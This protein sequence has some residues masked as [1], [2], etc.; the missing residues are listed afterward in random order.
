MGTDLEPPDWFK[1]ISK[2]VGTSTVLALFIMVCLLVLGVVG[3]M[4]LKILN[5]M[6]E[7]AG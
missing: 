6:G 4:V 5:A 2:V 3:A 7:W 1:K